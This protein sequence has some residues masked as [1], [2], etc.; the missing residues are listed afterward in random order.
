MV[1]CNTDDTFRTLWGGIFKRLGREV[2]DFSPEG[3][4]FEIEKLDPPALIVIDELDRLE[5][6]EALTLLADTIKTLSD[7]A[8]SST[9]VLVG[10]ANSIE[11]L[12]GE[13]QSI[14]RNLSQVEMPRM[15]PDE[16]R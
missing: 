5:D 7:H 15:R 13:H 8:V 10:V 14:L 9:I 6:N 12:I 11:E 2:D 16:L 1:N 4:R 3:I